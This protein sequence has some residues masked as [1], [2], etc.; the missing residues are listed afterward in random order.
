MQVLFGIVTV[1]SF[2]RNEVGVSV[3]F[4]DIKTLVICLLFAMP[5]VA[6]SADFFPLEALPG[7]SIGDNLPS[8]YEAS[9]MLWH[10]RLQKFFL[11]S[12][13]GYVSSM[14]ESGTDINHWQVDGDLE[15]V[16]VAFPQSNVIYLGIE[17]P[18]SIAEFNIVT[19]K[20]TRTFDLTQWMDGPKNSGLEALTFVPDATDPEGGLFYAGLQDTGQIF[21]FRLP[22]LSSSTRTNVTPIRT[23]SALNGINEISGLHYVPSQHVIYAIYDNS[24]LVRALE[25]GG[26]L[27][28]EWELPGRDQ[29]GIALKGTELYICEDYGKSGG[30]GVFRYAPF[31]GIA[32]PDLN[33]D[34]RVNLQ[35]FSLLAA[36]WKSGQ[37]ATG[38][39]FN[40]DGVIDAADIA[41]FFEY[42]LQGI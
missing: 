32:Q 31:V 39:D 26:S 15:A 8:D 41:I 2:R 10:S 21:V 14:S 13:G 28:R 20:V 3:S 1:S 7:V 24:N 27:I 6:W 30:S 11:V 33:S 29:E 9:G 42:W 40:G 12:D 37:N 18:D 34:G 19:G 22:I 16:T 4:M 23:I 36:Y 17:H 5:S 35:D 25:T 38:A